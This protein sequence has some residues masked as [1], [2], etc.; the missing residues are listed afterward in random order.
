MH[1]FWMDS[2]ENKEGA[3]QRRNADCVGFTD[4][5]HSSFSFVHNYHVFDI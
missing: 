5:Y 3:P 1:L 2:M 4:I